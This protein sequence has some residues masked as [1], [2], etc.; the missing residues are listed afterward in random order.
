ME[1]VI[2]NFIEKRDSVTRS[3]LFCTKIEKPF[4]SNIE[5]YLQDT[6]ELWSLVKKGRDQ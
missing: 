1:K 3:K 5:D 2:E 4:I 6:T